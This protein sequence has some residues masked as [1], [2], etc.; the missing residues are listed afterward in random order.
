MEVNGR[1]R[2]SIY[3]HREE[4]SVPA[5]PHTLS[6]VFVNEITILLP[7]GFELKKFRSVVSVPAVLSR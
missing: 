5:G 2:A 1:L 7:Q 3:L 4:Y 6:A